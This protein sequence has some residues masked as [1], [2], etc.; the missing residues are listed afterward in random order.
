VATYRLW[1]ATNGHPT[2]AS[3]APISLGT[4]IALSATGWVT[5]LHMWRA[6]LSETGPVTGAIYNVATGVQVPGT[7]VTYTLSGTGWQTVTLAT[8]VQLSA[9]TRYIVVVHHTDRYAGTASYWT[10]GPGGSG[11]TNGILTAPPNSAVVTAPVGQGR[12]TEAGTIQAPTSTFNGG[13]YWADL[14]VTDVNPGST[15][16]TATPSDLLG[17]TDSVSR[18]LDTTRGPAELIGL[19]DQADT[20]I[21]AVRSA[22]EALGLTDTAERVLDTARDTNDALGLTD[23]VTALIDGARSNTDTLGLTDSVHTARDIHITVVDTLGLTDSAAGGIAAP[24]A[25][26]DI[27]IGPPHTSWRIGPPH[28]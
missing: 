14:D 5:A 2:D 26:H 19:V 28:T 3:T 7:A 11:I 4:E 20:A 22:T 24:G 23:S 12:Y 21:D 17:L 10:S 8:P 13:G 9:S 15:D 6:T 18:V 25:D 1:P 27:H 16:H